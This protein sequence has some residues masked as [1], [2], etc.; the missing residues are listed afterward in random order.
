MKQT[1]CS[2]ANGFWGYCTNQDDQDSPCTSSEPSADCLENE[3]CCVKP[4]KTNTGE[5]GTCNSACENKVQTTCLLDSGVVPC[6]ECIDG[7]SWCCVEVCLAPP[8]DPVSDPALSAGPPVSDSAFGVDPAL[9]AGPVSVPASTPASGDHV[10]PGG[11]GVIS[12]GPGFT[13]AVLA[14]M[15]LIASHEV[16]HYLDAG[17]YYKN[18]GVRGSKGSFTD[19]DI[20]DGGGFPATAV[21]PKHKFNVG[22]YQFNRNDFNDCVKNTASHP[23]HGHT[24]TEYNPQQQDWMCLWKLSRRDVLPLLT[25]NVDDESLK[26]AIRNAGHEWASLPESVLHQVQEGYTIDD[27]VHIFRTRLAY[28]QDP[29]TPM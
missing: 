1:P 20:Q 11:N 19:Q 12:R 25:D 15:D 23:D 8:S 16:T 10:V 6:G 17:S 18:N 26:N 21:T 27:A 24:I 28:Y 9:S 3:L 5:E 13:P 29:A 14:F 4:C 7:A 22:R 2:T